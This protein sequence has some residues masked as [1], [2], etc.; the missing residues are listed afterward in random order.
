MTRVNDHAFAQRDIAITAVAGRFPGAP[1]P[2]AFWRSLLDGRELIRDYPAHRLPGGVTFSPVA[3]ACYVPRGAFLD[4]TDAFDY[5]FFHITPREA[6]RMDPQ[7]RI[8]LEVCHEAL[9]SGGYGRGSDAG[10]ASVFAGTR[11]SGWEPYMPAAADATDAMLALGGNSPDALASRTAYKLNCTGP[12]VSVATYCSGS[13]VSV[14]LACQSLLAG[15]SDLAIAGGACVRFP[16]HQGYFCH[17]G[18]ILSA[19]GRVRAFDQTA[20][21]PLCAEG[22]AAVLV[23]RWEGPR[24]AGEPILA[25]IKGSAVNNDGARRAG[26]SAPA[27]D[28][29][30]A[31][32][33]RAWDRAGVAP[34]RV[35]MIEAHGTGTSIGDAIELSSLLRVFALAQ[36]RACALGSLKTN[37]GHADCASGITGLIKTILAVQQGIIPPTL[38]CSRPMNALTAPHTPFYLPHAAQQWET[39][40]SPRL[41]GVSS[42]GIGGTNAHV[43]VAQPPPYAPDN[44]GHESVHLIPLSARSPETLRQI[45]ENLRAYLL[46]HPDTSADDVAYTLQRGRY[47]LP[48]R[49]IVLARDVP[50]IL[51]G[52]S[53]ERGVAV[54]CDGLLDEQRLAMAT[55]WQQ[56]GEADWLRF[57]ALEQ[58][59]RLP[60]PTYPFV[61]SRLGNDMDEPAA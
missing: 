44:T 23:R 35:G 5:G 57:Y 49:R 51:Y 9:E 21:G 33:Q 17:R 8:F 30:A 37:L 39:A 36:P 11:K 60:L 43:V 2:Q 48:V 32:I 16:A 18:G 40:G 15:E 61:R 6:V 53:Q 7:Q 52:L 29:Q 38:Y 45:T 59:R 42:F 34:D 3:G 31:V 24:P 20:D 26:Y 25:V 41:A 55:A 1:S 19:T 4:D 54:A 47:P 27:A 10:I 14:H 50:G 13:L 46:A 12:A 22:V 28:G 56:G 58:R